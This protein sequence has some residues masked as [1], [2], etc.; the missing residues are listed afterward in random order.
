MEVQVQTEQKS[1]TE[2][3]L[4][5]TI[6]AEVM[7]QK[8][9]AALDEMAG[10]IVLPGFRQGHIP[11]K[12]LDQRFGTAVAQEAL[13]EVLQEGYRDALTES[14][15]EP[16][17]PGDMKDVQYTPGEPLTFTVD[18]E[19]APDFELPV[20][21]EITVEALQPVVEEE[22]VLKMLDELRE[23]HA[24]VAPSDDP[25]DRDSII[26][27][28]L[29]ELD[30]TG[31]PILGREQK[32]AELDM[33]RSRLGEEFAIKVIGLIPGETAVVEFPAH[34]HEHEGQTHEHKAQRYQITIRTIRRKELPALDDDMAKLLNPQ[35][36]SLDALKADLKRYLEARANHQA[37][38]RMFRA[39]ADELLRKTDFTVPP[40]MLDDY[41]DHMAKDAVKGRKGRAVDPKEIERFK[42]E[43]RTSAIWN[44]RW[45][46][47][48]KKI[49][50][51]R[52]IEV[53]DDDYK[54]EV[55]RLA[56]VDEMK[57]SDFE[58][59]L[60]DEQKDRI[61][62]D[63]LERKVLAVIES[64]VQTVPRQVTLAEFEGRATPESDIVTA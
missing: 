54:G 17:S 44:L 16:V 61:R 64:E 18:V 23:S 48:R 22:D 19:V 33:S 51:D 40:R 35:I 38:E 46:M 55:E 57:K 4:K 26:T 45:H 21:S 59:K 43:Y 53:T 62:E 29:Q 39:V 50:S 24:V 25:V 30:E 10:K 12:V 60:N 3:E 14:K 28:D 32:D 41:L 47:L 52:Q 31:L 20:L 1:P 11:R 13:Q 8:V 63:I 15:L 37:H 9:K 58:K 6:P 7:E 42:D 49:I 2:Y 56:K 36:E 5:V 34:S 27:F